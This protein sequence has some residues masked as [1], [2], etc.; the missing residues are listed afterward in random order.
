MPIGSSISH[1]DLNKTDDPSAYWS[2]VYLDI[3][4]MQ[5]AK[6]GNICQHS[7]KNENK[8]RLTTRNPHFSFWFF[9]QTIVWELR[10]PEAKFQSDGSHNSVEII[11][12]SDFSC[13]LKKTRQSLP[14]LVSN[15]AYHLLHT[16][17]RIYNVCNDIR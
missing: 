5:N 10:T 4:I 6:N 16:K 17:H 11:K 7:N 14:V 1:M 15:C 3:L 13:K 9:N 2:K 12:M 8:T